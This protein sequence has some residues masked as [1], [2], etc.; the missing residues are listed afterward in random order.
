MREEKGE[1]LE[2]NSDTAQYW[3]ERGYD[4]HDAWL[5]G[6]ADHLSALHAAAVA[7]LPSGTVYEIRSAIPTDFGR[8]VGVAWYHVPKMQQM[9]LVAMKGY[10]GVLNELGGFVLMGRV[11]T[12]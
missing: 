3:K 6:M 10:P 7:Q 4:S 2:W 1:A 12:P 5:A 8:S 11:R 9:E